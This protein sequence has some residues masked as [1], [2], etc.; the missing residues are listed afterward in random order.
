MTKDRHRRRKDQLIEDDSERLGYRS[1]GRRERAW[2]G[3][4]DDGTRFGLRKDAGRNAMPL[5]PCSNVL[6]QT[7][8]PLTIIYPLSRFR[9]YYRYFQ[10]HLR[11]MHAFYHHLRNQAFLGSYWVCLSILHE[12]PNNSPEVGMQPAARGENT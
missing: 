6:E 8:H 12:T 10:A 5:D 1:G 9:T 7:T 4:G 3:R 2:L 11:I